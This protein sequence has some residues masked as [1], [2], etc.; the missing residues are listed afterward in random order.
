MAQPRVQRVG[1][2]KVRDRPSVFAFSVLGVDANDAALFL[3]EAQGVMVRSGRHCV[4]SWYE[5]RDL[6]AT[7]RASFY[8][9][10][11]RRTMPTGWSR[12]LEEL[13]SRIPGPSAGA[14]DPTGARY[15][16]I[17][18]TS[19][20]PESAAPFSAARRWMSRSCCSIRSA[21]W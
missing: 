6:A 1:P 19:A 13:L 17:G 12:G 7:V 4:H 18:A 21:S 9:Y 15:R 11:T 3:D 14:R 10:N 5:E 16:Y 8:L 2:A 20:K